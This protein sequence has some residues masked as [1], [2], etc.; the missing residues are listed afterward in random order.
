MDKDFIFKEIVKT[1][2]WGAYLLRTMK[3]GFGD[4]GS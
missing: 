2:D 3:S 1:S 4:G